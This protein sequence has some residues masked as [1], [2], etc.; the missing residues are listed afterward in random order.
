MNF[1]AAIVLYRGSIAG[2]GPAGTTLEGF[3]CC[4]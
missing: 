4:V 3:T 1:V 2:T